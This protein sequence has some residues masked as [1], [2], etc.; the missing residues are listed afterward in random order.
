MIP[1]FRCDVYLLNI[2]NKKGARE[3]SENRFSS[4]R[5]LIVALYHDLASKQHSA[6]TALQT[7]YIYLCVC[8]CARYKIYPHT[9][10]RCILWLLE[11]SAL[12]FLT[13]PFAFIFSWLSRGCFSQL[14][15]ELYIYKK[16]LRQGWLLFHRPQKLCLLR[17][18]KAEAPPGRH[19]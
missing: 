8:M 6:E 1:M 17:P 3:T 19:R 14:F 5:M 12:L 7:T 13:F 18:N 2:T 4:S 11:E 16:P 9:I 10:I 15:G